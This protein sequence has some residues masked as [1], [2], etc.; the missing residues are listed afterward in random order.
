M[1]SFLKI[2]ENLNT[3]CV[4]DSLE[5]NSNFWDENPLRRTAYGTAHSQMVD[6]WVRF[7]KIV[8]GDYSKVCVD[9]ESEWY[10][11]ADKI[12]GLKEL[13]FNVMAL[14]DGER[15]GGVL[16]T[17]LPAGKAIDPHIDKGW[18]A[19]YYEKFYVALK[20]PEGSVF[21]FPDSEIT[22]KDGE[23]YLFRNDRMHWVKNDSESDRIALIICIK[24]DKYK[25][26]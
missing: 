25:G 21:G 14:V 23:C 17:K 18:H 10:D 11:S 4:V 5:V 6:I 8:D 19:E 7:G 26:I 9:H 24:T 22:A 16:I 20:N 2:A 3:E 15:L 13:I 12:D 1:I